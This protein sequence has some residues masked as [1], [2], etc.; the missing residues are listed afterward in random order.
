MQ[1]EQTKIGFKIVS[2]R[3]QMS[4]DL[5][6][7]LEKSELDWTKSENFSDETLGAAALGTVS[8]ARG[9]GRGESP[10]LPVEVLT[11]KIFCREPSNEGVD[12]MRIQR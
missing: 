10:A 2:E 4:Q 7:S 3:L 9:I 8:F 1:L 12:V 5:P 6:C 11:F